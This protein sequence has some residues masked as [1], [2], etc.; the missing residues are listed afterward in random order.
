MGFWGAALTSAIVN[1]RGSK[2]G[3]GRGVGLERA[4]VGVG[5]VGGGEDLQGQLAVQPRAGRAGHTHQ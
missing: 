2:R 4:E 1:W 5:Q 3:R